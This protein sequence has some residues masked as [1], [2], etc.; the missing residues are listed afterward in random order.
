MHMHCFSIPGSETLVAAARGSG[1]KLLN[2]LPGKWSVSSPASVDNSYYD[3]E[4]L[5]R[6]EVICLFDC[7]SCQAASALAFCTPHAL[8]QFIESSDEELII[9]GM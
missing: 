9:Y 6:I 8:Y 2:T 7:V 3:G 1:L 5:G 4:V